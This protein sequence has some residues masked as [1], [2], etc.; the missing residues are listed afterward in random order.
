MRR[1]RSMPVVVSSI[2]PSI[3]SACPGSSSWTDGDEVG[4][5]VERDVGARRDERADVVGVGGRVLAAH[6]VDLGPVGLG[7]GG[8]HVVLGRQRV[9]G[10]ERGPRAAGHERPDEVRG[11]G[12][13]VQA[14]RHRDAVERPLGREALADEAQDRHLGVGPGDPVLARRRERRVGDGAH[15]RGT[16]TGAGRASTGSGPACT[17]PATGTPM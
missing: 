16:E 14:R 12:R 3:A 4:A 13:D 15:G 10:A 17:G 6:G 1:T 7:Q 9:G 8:G 5:V 2:A 11:L